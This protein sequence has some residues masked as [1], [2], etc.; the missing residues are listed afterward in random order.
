MN[1]VQVFFVHKRTI[2]V[3]KWIQFDSNGM[4]NI[5]LRGCWF[6]TIVTSIHASTDDKTDDVKD[7]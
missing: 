3:V 5:I 1:L 6:H 4:P 7:N 2:S